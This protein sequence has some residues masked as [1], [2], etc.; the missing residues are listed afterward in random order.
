MKHSFSILLT[1]GILMLIGVALIPRLDIADK[2]RP[3]QGK[4]LTVS[5][6]WWGASAKVIE[7]NV[8]SRI[9]GLV[10]SV[11]G[12]ESVSSVSYFGSGNV[13][14]HLKKDASVSGVKFEIASLLRQVRDK[15]PE[16]VSYPVLSGGEVITG[17][18]D[19]EKSKPLLTYLIQADMAGRDIRKQVERELKPRLEREE[20]VNRVEV[21]GGTDFYLQISYD[22]T[23]LSLYGIT[24][25]DI[26]EAIRNQLGRQ[27]IVGEVM[28][29]EPEGTP[30]R[31]SLFLGVDAGDLHLESMPIKT[32]DGKIIYLNN[33]ATCPYDGIEELLRTEHETSLQEKRLQVTNYAA[34]LACMCV[35]LFKCAGE[36]VPY[37]CSRIGDFKLMTGFKAY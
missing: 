21:T 29:M 3:R 26:E 28:R 37:L 36:V 16:G 9:E 27:D 19:D 2:P 34:C 23:Q 17:K 8:T 10:S 20:G 12:V 15:F 33:L 35:Y 7:Q 30:T 6:S 4:T 18:S 25:S 11:K 22:A 24:A 13:T 31:T 5:Y 14:V 32:L 1:M